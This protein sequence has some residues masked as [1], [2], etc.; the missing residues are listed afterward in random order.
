MRGLNYGD[1]A[2]VENFIQD[3]L[4]HLPA[5]QHPPPPAALRDLAAPGAARTT[6]LFALR[7]GPLRDR[8]ADPRGIPQAGFEATRTF[9]LNYSNLWAQDVSRRLGYAIDAVVYGKDLSPSCRRGCPR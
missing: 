9:L 4:V 8:Q 7:A 6:A 1:Y 2:Y 3:G 5:A